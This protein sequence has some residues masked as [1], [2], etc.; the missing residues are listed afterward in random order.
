MRHRYHRHSLNVV[1]I[2][3]LQYRYGDGVAHKSS[4]A[5]FLVMRLVMRLIR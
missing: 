2:P 3:T 4:L 1:S 5:L